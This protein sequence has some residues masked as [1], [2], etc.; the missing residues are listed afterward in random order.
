MGR[1]GLSTEA[2]NE[3]E[4]GILAM[5]PMKRLGKPEEVASVV[6]FLASQGSSYITGVEI[7]VDGGIGELSRRTRP[8]LTKALQRPL[9]DARL[10][11]DNNP[12][13][14][15]KAMKHAIS[16]LLLAITVLMVAQAQKNAQAQET[17][18]TAQT[19]KALEEKWVEALTKSDTATLD[20][21]FSDSY[22]DTD[23]HGQRT[24]KQGVLSALKSGD[25]KLESIKL[26]DMQV[27]DYGDAAVVT[28]SASQAGSFKGQ[29]LVPKIVFTDTFVRQNG[30]W[31]AVA[32]HRTRT[33]P[34]P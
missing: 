31:R 21:I 8:T 12:R 26:S 33:L 9:L 11:A 34:S 29:A 23:E 6:A 3:F 5:V 19:L 17:E 30:K 10:G 4:Q 25:L 1:L 15:G 7:N 16:A 24:D 2:A 28:G 18:P 22:V 13:Q 14:G 27:H 32:S 20:S